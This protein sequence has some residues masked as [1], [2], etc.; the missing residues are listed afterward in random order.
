MVKEADAVAWNTHITLLSR[1]KRYF[2][3]IGKSKIW[4]KEDNHISP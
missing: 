3:K 4:I 2:A 1:K